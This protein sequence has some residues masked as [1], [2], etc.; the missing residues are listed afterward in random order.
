MNLVRRVL[1]IPVWVRLVSG[2]TALLGAMSCATPN[3][4]PA[5]ME[6][7]EVRRF[8]D[9]EVIPYNLDSIAIAAGAG[10]LGQI[11]GAMIGPDSL[12]YVLDRYWAKIVAFRPDGAVERVILGGEGKGP[13]EFETPIDITEADRGF[14]VLD[15]GL[16]RITEFSWS[17]A[18][19]AV[20]RLQSR[21]P[22]RHVIRGDTVWIGYSSGGP[23]DGPMFYRVR[24]T[25][26]PLDSGP[27]LPEED[28]PFGTGLGMATSPSGELLVTSTRPGVWYSETRG[29]WSRRGR[30]LYP[31]T[32]P[33]AVE[34]TGPQQSRVT[35]AQQEA[36]GIGLLGDS[37][38]LQGFYS[39]P[40]P[41]D[42]HSPPAR[43]EFRHAV[44]VF[45]ID[46]Q[47]VATIYL[48]PGVSTGYL[49]S[50]P[51]S[52]RILL[53]TSDPYPQVIEYRLLGCADTARSGEEREP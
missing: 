43:D 7:K 51:A 50:E 28:R 4:T 38:V 41:F 2:A 53:D 26:E 20:H 46:G 9:R 31:S 48:P 30:P 12:V 19:L 37:I 35:P 44:A 23:T 18:L 11:R 14:S 27:P 34:Q 42:W 49:F 32:P 39:L 8:G 52:G 33:P 47:H 15:Y 16:I 1:S 45:R 24:V 36:A 6:L 17:G 5:C 29:S 22:W 3:R 25:G 21:P 40:R 13:G 10:V